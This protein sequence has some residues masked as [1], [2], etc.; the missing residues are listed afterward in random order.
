MIGTLE[1]D[2]AMTKSKFGD[3]VLYFRHQ[4]MNDDVKIKSDWAK[5]LPTVGFVGCPYL[6]GLF[7][8]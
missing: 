5:Y 8:N 2:G 1:L 7:G 3:E 6:K 4:L